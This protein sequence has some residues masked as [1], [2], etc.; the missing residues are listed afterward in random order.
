MNTIWD[1]A[2]LQAALNEITAQMPSKL[3]QCVD[4]ACLAI[5]AEAKERCPS[6]TGELRRSI[7]SESKVNGDTVEGIVGTNLEYAPYV[8]EGTG[9]YASNG[10]GRKEVPWCYYD[11][12]KGKFSWT[13]GIKPHPFLQE[14]A[15]SI[16]PSILDYFKGLLET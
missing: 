3:Q 10:N 8:H 5:E 1:D 7:Q 9:I 13:K 6:A 2:E 11:E 12:S 4:N 16:E 15:E 14:A